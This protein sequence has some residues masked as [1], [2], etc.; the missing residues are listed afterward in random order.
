MFLSYTSCLQAE[1]KNLDEFWVTW[2]KNKSVEPG[3]SRTKQ[4]DWSRTIFTNMI[5]SVPSVCYWECR[6][7]LSRLLL[8][9][10]RK[11]GT[12]IS[13]NR[14]MLNAIIKI[15]LFFFNKCSLGYYNF[16]LSS[17]NVKLF[18]RFYWE[19][20]FWSCVLCCSCWCHPFV[21]ILWIN[22][23][24]IRRRGN[25]F[26]GQQVVKQIVPSNS[27]TYEKT[28]FSDLGKWTVIHTVIQT[29]CFRSVCGQRHP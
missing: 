26:R 24:Q 11:D 1:V 3:F 5:H 16:F 23:S 8:D 17:Q 20:D 13:W 19:M 28:F 29:L 10:K 22:M 14:T 9:L 25:V 21:S 7:L 6:L 4:A 18:T 12:S 27:L 2:D 15:Q